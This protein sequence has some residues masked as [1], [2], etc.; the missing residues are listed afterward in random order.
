M[1]GERKYALEEEVLA[2]SGCVAE[3]G[4]VARV[5][6]MN[7]T[8]TDCIEQ[9]T[10]RTTKCIPHCDR[11]ALGTGKRIFSDPAIHCMGAD[12]R[13]SHNSIIL[14]TDRGER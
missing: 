4:L 2:A 13:G 6:I 5:I 9:T 14:H 3:A 1:G 12:V 11:T 7:L 10:D 8:A